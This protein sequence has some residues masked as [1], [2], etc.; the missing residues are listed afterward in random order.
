MNPLK[1]REELRRMRKGDLFRLASDQRLSECL[2]GA[3]ACGLY[4]KYRGYSFCIS[5]L[6][7]T[8][9]IYEEPIRLR[10]GGVSEGV[11]LPIFPWVHSPPLSDKEGTPFRVY[12][13]DASTR[14]LIFLGEII[15]RRRKERKDNLRDLLLMARRI[16]S[17]R[18][19][20]TDLIFLL[21]P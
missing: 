7:G 5:E 18:V 15:E 17:D 21:G 6:L 20:N 13:R 9:C 12:W 2:V 10:E 3:R 14:A 4:L 19:S 16:F 1:A 8:G 11:P